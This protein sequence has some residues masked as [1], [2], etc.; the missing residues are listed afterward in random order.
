MWDALLDEIRSGSSVL[1]ATKKVGMPCEKAFYK[2]R[3]REPEFREKADQAIADRRLALEEITLDLYL[4]QDTSASDKRL[5]FDAIDR[6]IG[7][8][9]PKRVEISGG[10]N[11]KLSLSELTD[12]QLLAIA[13]SRS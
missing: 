6:H 7:R 11:S 9:S 1:Q 5:R 10:L 12:E 13:S 3:I 2:K 4:D 8:M